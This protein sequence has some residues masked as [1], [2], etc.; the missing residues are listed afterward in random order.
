VVVD[1]GHGGG[2]ANAANQ[3]VGGAFR[4]VES[5]AASLG[6]D[7]EE[8]VRGLAARAGGGDDGGSDGSGGDGSSPARVEREA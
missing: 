1:A 5:F 6:V 4:F 2:V 3:R 8:L 7:V